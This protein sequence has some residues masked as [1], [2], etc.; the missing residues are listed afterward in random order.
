MVQLPDKCDE[1]SEAAKAGY[2]TIA[3]ISKERIRRAGKKIK[4]EMA[5]KMTE[6]LGYGPTGYFQIGAEVAAN[7]GPRIVGVAFD[8][9]K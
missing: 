1:K 3:E 9:K 7:A 8:A 5:A 4:E 6:K 2:K